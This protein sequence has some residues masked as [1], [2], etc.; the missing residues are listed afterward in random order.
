MVNDG[1]LADAK[2]STGAVRADILAELFDRLRYGNTDEEC[3]V[4]RAVATTRVPLSCG[5]CA[6]TTY[7]GLIEARDAEHLRHDGA[8]EAGWYAE[9]EAYTLVRSDLDLIGVIVEQ[10]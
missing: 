2:G 10:V 1:L 7:T 6:Y 4:P 8:H 5:T 9:D 3:R